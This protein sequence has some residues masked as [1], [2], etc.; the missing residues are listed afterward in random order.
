MAAKPQ[1]GQL[2]N[3][4]AA[5]P[6][7]K[8]V[9]LGASGSVGSTCI[10]YLSRLDSIDLAAVSVHA[11]V[12]RLKELLR[13]AS[14]SRAAITD[15]IAFEQSIEEL[16]GLFPETQFYPGHEGMLAM[17]SDAA[18]E[19]ADTVLT[20]LVGAVGIEATM[21]SLRLGLKVALANKETLVTAGPAIEA[22]IAGLQENGGKLPVI[23]P[24]DSEH[25][26]IFQALLGRHADEV[27]R[28]ILTASGGPFRERPLA[29][30]EHV[31]KDQVLDHPTWSMG[32]KIT[33]DSAGM[34]NKGLELIEAHY[35]F[36]VPYDDLG[37]Y[38]HK[39]SF[40]H[41]MIETTDGGFLLAA[42]S[43]NMVFPVAHALHF[44][45][46]VPR[47]LITWFGPALEPPGM[48]KMLSRLVPRGLPA[49]RTVLSSSRTVR[50][51]DVTRRSR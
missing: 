51:I 5:T 35:L 47:R 29:E 12:G 39:D 30:L 34:I 8:L 45:A 36:S 23:V 37:V 46:A 9:L 15:Q 17:L 14:I 4:R 25:N 43:P 24:V 32:P 13:A 21:L 41:G 7:R 16:E 11:S 27:Q 26:A 33:V 20:A 38:V 18:A 40:V 6:T 1:I 44:P 48:R 22:L 2:L 28:L 10:E 49:K 50:V 19:G 3:A 42:S 31:T